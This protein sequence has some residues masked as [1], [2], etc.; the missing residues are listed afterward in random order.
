MT[1]TT[2][3]VAALAGLML[4]LGAL[5]APVEIAGVK[6]DDPVEVHGSKLQLNGAGIRSTAVLKV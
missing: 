2:R 1:L 6:L 5:A 3:C 4:S